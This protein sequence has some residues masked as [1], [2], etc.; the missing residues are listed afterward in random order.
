MIIKSQN[1]WLDGRLQPASV[2]IENG[3][4]TAVLPYGPADVD[5]G[6]NYIMPGFID[7]HTHGNN[8]VA[9]A[10]SPK[11]EIERWQREIT[12]DGVTAFMA[13]T[14]TESHD[15]NIK[16]LSTVADCVGQG[17]GAEILGIYMEG[18]FINPA[19]KGAHDEKLIMSPNPAVLQEYI[20]ACHGTMKLMILAAE[21]DTT[22]EMMRVAAKNGVKVMVGHSSATYEEVRLAHRNGAVGITHTFNGMRPFNH[23][24]TGIVGA[25]LTISDL[26]A[27]II[28]DGHH[29]S[30][31]AVKLLAAMK[32][33]YHLIMVTDASPFKDWQGEL[34]AGIHR[35]A[36]GQFRNQLGA[37]SSSSLRVCD[38]IFNMI[39]KADVPFEKA[40]NAATIN[41]ATMLGVNDRKG[42]IAVGKDADIAVVTPDFQ[43]VETYCR[44][45]AMLAR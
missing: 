28:T 35:D 31:P 3:V 40:V 26:Y 6:K 5:Y 11:N 38:G 10:Y 36:E 17:E 1:V 7:I 13:T 9:S 19:S 24:E 44:G 39:T 34:P 29:V 18:N 33:N 21:L 22:G 14:A 30:W 37:L 8:G 2:E 41:P 32:D 43:V 23:R 15:D 42:S 16:T 25:A 4:F 12:A 20:D 45:K 27:E